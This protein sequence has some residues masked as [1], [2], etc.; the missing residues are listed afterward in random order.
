MRWKLI[1]EN[2]LTYFQFKWKNNLAIYSTISS[3]EKILDRYKPIF[4]KQIHSD[5][6]INIDTI[7]NRIGDGLISERKNCVIGLKVADCLPVYLFNEEK[8]CIIH[9]GWRGI[10]KGIAKK[11][12][13]YF[14]EYRY[15]LGASINSCCYEVNEHIAEL[16]CRKYKNAVVFKNRKYILDLK[17]AVIEDLG[18]KNLLTSLDYCT[19]CHPEY[20]YS[21]RRGDNKKR[22]YALLLSL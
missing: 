10:I 15:V 20:F 1:V 6:I 11:A 21:Y 2:N 18:A 12:A 7:T 22:N 5:V 14:A 17:T 13:M 9:C 19:K 16:F 4:L 3:E 8:I